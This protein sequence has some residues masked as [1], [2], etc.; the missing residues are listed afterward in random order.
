MNTTTTKSSQNKGAKGRPKMDP[1]EKKGTYTLTC[2]REVWKAAKAIHG[3]K[4]SSKIEDF[5][6]ILNREIKGQG[7]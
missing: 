5:L 6:K 3:R 4:L 7:A 2:N 1:A